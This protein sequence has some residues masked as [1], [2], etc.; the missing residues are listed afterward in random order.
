V[1]AHDRV[2]ELLARRSEA[3]LS[4]AETAEAAGLLA[5]PE[6][7]QA[8][9]ADRRTDA[10]LAALL[11]PAAAE[12]SVRRVAAALA[13][14]TPSARLRLRGRLPQRS[15][16]RRSP[17]RG[18]LLPWL[19]AA[20]IL[21]LSVAAWLVWQPGRPAAP[22]GPLPPLVVAERIVAPGPAQLLASG[23]RVQVRSGSLRVANDDRWQL[24]A[25]EITV[26][27]APRPVVRPLVIALPGAAV[28]VVGTRFTV[29]SVAGTLEVA[30]ASGTVRCA[31]SGGT[32][33]A[34][35]AGERWEVAAGRE[36]RES[37]L[38]HHR[39]AGESLE[40]F[41]GHPAAMDGPDGR[42]CLPGVLVN[43][44]A[45]EWGIYLS[46]WDHG[47]APLTGGERLRC[48]IHLAAG[49]PAPLLRID[50]LGTQPFRGRVLDVPRDR[51]VEIDIALAD[52]P[53]LDGGTSAPIP[54][55]YVLGDLALLMPA[56]GSPAIRI[57]D[58]RLVRVIEDP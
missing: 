36:R 16:S 11:R 17:R 51:W 41:S 27:A 1:S 4:A 3:G 23:D 10:L 53:L 58:L 22:S 35:T 7:A 31:R 6:V 9:W 18:P 54:A 5:D 2:A 30:V 13:A 32:S 39:F 29:R 8:V 46:D 14:T 26:D 33:H 40:R 37:L 15:S 48:A 43:S 28:T 56:T 55:G 20:A 12:R 47:L 50:G 21:V 25:G 24:D 57:A 49:A 44:T 38:L 42:R 45:R 34:I 19:A 52:L